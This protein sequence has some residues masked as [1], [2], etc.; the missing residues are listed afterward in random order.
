MEFVSLQPTIN[1]KYILSKINQ[2]SIMQH[3]TGINVNSKKFH[4][5]DCDSVKDMSEKNKKVFNGKRQDLIDSGYEPCSS[6]N[7]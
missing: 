6:C 7:P 2:E 4:R 5:P 1:K 3:Y